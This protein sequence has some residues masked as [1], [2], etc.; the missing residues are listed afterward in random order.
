MTV[1]RFDFTLAFSDSASVQ[2]GVKLA[3]QVFLAVM[4]ALFTSFYLVKLFWDGPV[5]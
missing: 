1:L 2:V 4:L 5:K 3:H